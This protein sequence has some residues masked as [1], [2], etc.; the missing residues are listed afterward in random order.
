MAC[1]TTGSGNGGWLRRIVRQQHGHNSQNIK[2][3][4]LSLKL[5][6]IVKNLRKLS[7]MLTNNSKNSAQNLC[8][9]YPLRLVPNDK[10]SGTRDQAA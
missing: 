7:S 1:R 4:N 6:F 8:Q 3:V 5:L 2:L 9:I 10:S